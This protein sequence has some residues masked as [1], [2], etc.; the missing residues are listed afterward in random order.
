MYWFPACLLVL[1]GC[2]R[3]LCSEQEAASKQ[4]GSTVEW[5]REMGCV[6]QT[7]LGAGVDRCSRQYGGRAGEERCREAYAGTQ[8]DSPHTRGLQPQKAGTK[9]LTHLTFCQHGTFRSKLQLRACTSDEGL[10]LRMTV[11]SLCQQAVCG[12]NRPKRPPQHRSPI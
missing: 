11:S 8:D 5:K 12:I 7:V 9:E 10:G 1:L 3:P 2:R 6:F 4:A